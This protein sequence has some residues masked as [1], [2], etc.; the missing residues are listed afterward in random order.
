MERNGRNRVKAVGDERSGSVW[1]GERLNL[2]VTRKEDTHG[3]TG[4]MMA[5]RRGLRRFQYRPAS[6]GGPGSL[7]CKGYFLV[8]LFLCL[9]NQVE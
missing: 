1:R 7:F 5:R 8:A 9:V 4:G 3:E 2:E 6:H